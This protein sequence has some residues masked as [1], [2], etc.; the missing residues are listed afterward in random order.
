MELSEPKPFAGNSL[1]ASV[2][3]K[4][5][6]AI[7]SYM[8]PINGIVNDVKLL[9]PEKTPLAKSLVD[10]GRVASVKDE[11]FSNAYSKI[12]FKLLPR[13]ILLKEV[14]PENALEPIFVTPFGKTMASKEEQLWNAC[15]AILVIVL[16]STTPLSSVKPS[17]KH[18]LSS[19]KPSPKAAYSKAVEPAKIWSPN[20]A[21]SLLVMNVFKALQLPKALPPIVMAGP[22]S[23]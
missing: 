18:W 8:P 16:G 12:V 23:I 19:V 21:M 17:N 9:Q 15:A 13:V 4:T 7:A 3:V 6:V 14:Q 1:L 22:S 11:Q 2:P 10:A 20:E 5:G